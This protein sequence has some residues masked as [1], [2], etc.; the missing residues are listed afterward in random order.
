MQNLRRQYCWVTQVNLISYSLNMSTVL[1]VLF[2]NIFFWGVCVCVLFIKCNIFSL[3]PPLPPSLFIFVPSSFYPLPIHCRTLLPHMLNHVMD[4]YRLTLLEHMSH[5]CPSCYLPC[6]YG[7]IW[8]RNNRFPQ[9][10]T[11]S[12]ILTYLKSCDQNEV[13]NSC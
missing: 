13:C 12:A 7:T 3:L 2:S 1:T 9:I 11:K 5:L 6:N 4:M 8:L 10:L